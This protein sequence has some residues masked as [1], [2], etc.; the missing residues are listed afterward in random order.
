[1]PAAWAANEPVL[2]ASYGSVPASTSVIVV[3]RF[4]SGRKSGPAR[5]LRF[6]DVAQVSRILVSILLAYPP[7]SRRQ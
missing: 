5:I 1:M 3:S 2:F 7:Y 4:L 6:F